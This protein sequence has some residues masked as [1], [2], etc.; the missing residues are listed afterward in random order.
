[1]A[2]NT[3]Q[4]TETEEVKAETKTSRIKSWVANHPRLTRVVGFTAAGLAVVGAVAAA[5]NLKDDDVDALT[6]GADVLELSTSTETTKVAE[7]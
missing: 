5:K 7:A 4:N 3:T 1:M 6:S 2:E